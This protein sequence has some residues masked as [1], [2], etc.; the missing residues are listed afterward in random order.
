[1]KHASQP[2]IFIIE[3]CDKVG[4]TTLAHDLSAKTSYPIVHLGVPSGADYNQQ[5]RALVNEHSGGVIFDRFHWGDFVYE[6]IT[7]KERLLNWGEFN[8]LES[9]LND[10]GA[11]VIYCSADPRELE[12]RFLADKESLIPAECIP[13][14]LERYQE[15]L[16]A[17]RLPVYH[18]D[19]LKHPF[20][21]L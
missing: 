18:H 4:K 7:N 8:V 19:F 5:L 14:I 2:K 6:G 16:K 9:R 1:M 20:I 17:T 15:L 11:V 12:A 21:I 10:L 3:G 13:K